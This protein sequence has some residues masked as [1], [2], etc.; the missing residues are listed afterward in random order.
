MEK[1]KWKKGIGIW[2]L[3]IGNWDGLDEVWDGEVVET[4]E[5]LFEQC[6]MQE[7][8]AA[9][10]ARRSHRAATG[11]ATSKWGYTGKRQKGKTTGKGNHKSSSQDQ[12]WSSSPWTWS[13]W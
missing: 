8:K 5:N 1:R 4:L 13:W 12:W 6:K 2:E 11:T 7:K 10:E 9:K 3:G